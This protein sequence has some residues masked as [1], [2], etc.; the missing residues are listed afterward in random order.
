MPETESGEFT[1]DVVDLDDEFKDGPF[2]FRR[3]RGVGA[4]WGEYPKPEPYDYY[5]VVLPHQ[6]DEWQVVDP[7]DR[8]E[9][10]AQME[11]FVDHA[12]GILGVMRQYKETT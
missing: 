2:A 5:E 11:K 12:Q 9:A 8:D 6:C 1:D 4:G 3:R 7:D 10:I